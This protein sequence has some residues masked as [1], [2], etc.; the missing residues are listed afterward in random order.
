[1]CLPSQRNDPR[2][3]EMSCQNL[4]LPM[5]TNKLLSHT[6]QGLAGRPHHQWFQKMSDTTG[7]AWSVGAVFEDLGTSC[8]NETFWNVFDKRHAKSRRA[9][10]LASKIWV[11]L[12]WEMNWEQP[13]A[14]C[15]YLVIGSFCCCEG[16]NKLY[17]ATC[18]LLKIHVIDHDWT[19]N[20][21]SIHFNP[22]WT[23]GSYNGL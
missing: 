20:Q 18:L 15:G 11:E 3:M 2:Q 21:N 23:W 10:E 13:S 17:A 19:W 1:M 4:L 5:R 22:D 12:A 7:S 16:Y 9:G 14:M 8:F 6:W